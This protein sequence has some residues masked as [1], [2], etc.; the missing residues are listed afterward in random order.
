MCEK[1]GRRIDKNRLDTQLAALAQPFNIEIVPETGSTNAD[2]MARM[3]ASKALEQPIVRIAYQQTAGRGRHGRQWLA[4]RGDAL[5]FSVASSIPRPIDQLSGLSLAV[6][7]A[8]L[9]GLRALPLTKPH[10]L[11]LKWPNDLLLDGAKLGGVLIETVRSTRDASIAVIGVG[12][13]LDGEDALAAQLDARAAPPA[14]LA[15]ILAEI[16]ITQVL[17]QVLNTLAAML[18]I[19]GKQGF[20]PFQSAWRTE[21]A[22]TGRNV[23]L[24]EQRKEIARGR[25]IGID[26]QGCLQIDTGAEMRL[27]S[28]G[29]LSLRSD[30]HL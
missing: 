14:A 16:D 18:K 15:R 2:L 26:V 29:E 13:N 8:V 24:F 19:F 12:L 1:S 30:P 27:I 3:R 6:G 23:I 17:A 21:H 4:R 9:N 5:L 10:R 28:N 22:Y 11:A 20:A 25:L 7:A